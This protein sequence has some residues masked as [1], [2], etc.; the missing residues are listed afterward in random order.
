MLSY[1]KQRNT[2]H[3][4]THTLPQHHPL[5][6]CPSIHSA[7]SAPNQSIKIIPSIASASV[8]AVSCK[9][10]ALNPINIWPL[11]PLLFSSLCWLTQPWITAVPR[12]LLIHLDGWISES[13]DFFLRQIKLLLDKK[14]IWRGFHFS[15]LSLSILTWDWHL[16]L[17]L[18]QP[19]ANL[20]V[21]MNWRLRKEY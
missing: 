7:C 14:D 20:N 21:E 19:L 16:L 13:A 17:Y 2:I 5:I 4:H 15:F 12:R 11:T 9:Q 1:L 8:W 18:S 10:L 6:C 3:T